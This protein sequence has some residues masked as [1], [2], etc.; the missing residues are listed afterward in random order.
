[1]THCG[2]SASGVGYLSAG[3]HRQ[4]SDLKILAHGPLPLEENL[5]N[6]KDLATPGGFAARDPGMLHR[7][8]R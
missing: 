2:T 8:H 7:K 3:L 1:M 4:T 5:K 6:W